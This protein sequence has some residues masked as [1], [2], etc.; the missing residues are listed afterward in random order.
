MIELRPYQNEAVHLLRNEFKE[1]H[2][3]II[4]CQPTGAGKSV[5][6]SY[7][8]YE[9]FK[10]DKKI[11]CLTDRIELFNQ[12]LAHIGRTGISPQIVTANTKA[13]S[14]TANVT[15]VRNYQEE[16]F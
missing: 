13:I 9:A 4:L 10:K 6:F 2:K 16:D 8:I 3:R 7:M 1:G 5:I 12:T 15:I 11:L 14:S